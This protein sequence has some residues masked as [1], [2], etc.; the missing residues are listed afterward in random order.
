MSIKI[1]EDQIVVLN[2]EKAVK[3]GLVVGWAGGWWRN[4][5]VLD[6]ERGVIEGYGYR[7]VFDGVVLWE[8][9]VGGE[10]L[11]RDG[12]VYE[13]EEAAAATRRTWAVSADGAVI[14]KIRD[15]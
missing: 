6:L 9:V 2:G 5:D 3:V 12:V 11:E 10:V 4:V 13:G 7:E 15:I 14:W 8:E 1:S